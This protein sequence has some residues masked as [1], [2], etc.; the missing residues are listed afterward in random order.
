MTTHAFT[1]LDQHPVPAA[2]DEIRVFMIVSNEVL[3]LP[4]ILEYYRN[5]G[6]NRFFIIDNG[7]TDGS[8]EFLKAQDDCHIF[9]TLASYAEARYG[10]LWRAVLLDE[11]GTGHWCLNVDADELLIYPQC[12]TVNLRQLCAYLDAEGSEGLYTFLMDMYPSG[13]IANAACVP[14]KPFF[15]IAP[16]FDADYTFVDRIRLRGCNPFPP[17]E[18][19]GG[20]RERCFYPDQGRTSAARRMAIHVYE[21]GA[22]ML[23]RAGLIKNFKSL[24]A[25]ALF[26]IPLV[27]WKKGLE[28][29]AST[30]VINPIA[31][32]PLT[33]ILAHFKFFSDFHERALNAV[34]T[35]A[36][37]N[38]SAEYK[39]YLKH[40]DKVRNLMYEGSR[41]YSSSHDALDCGLMKT[42]QDFDHQASGK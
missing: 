21:R 14:G 26:K 8:I 37:T 34:K 6:A 41:K 28:Y 36:H 20:P 9:S 29:K 18:V 11:Y 31:L 16:F 27:K 33:G 23:K 12:E 25:P 13:D 42:T 15:E 4:H 22:V 30:H 39:Q 2:P 40:I 10:I 5:M 24:K 1:R 3:R 32:S 19:M 7:S 35:G 38:N 17:Q